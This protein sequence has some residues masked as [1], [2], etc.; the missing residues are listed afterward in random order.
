MRGP[1]VVFVL[2]AAC[3]AGDGGTDAASAGFFSDVRIDANT[4]DR[5]VVRFGTA[6]PTSCE[7]LYGL[8]ADALDTT[9]TDP[10]MAPGQRVTDHN[11]PLE[12]LV[13]LTTYFFR[14]RAT[15]ASGH[16]YTS[17]VGTLT[18]AAG[19]A[20]LSMTDVAHAAMGTT[21]TQVSSNWSGEPDDGAWGVDH[22]IDGDMYT[23][24]SSNGDGNGAYVVLDF[25]QM[26]TVTYFGFRSR[27]MRD[28]T[29][30]I[31]SVR[32]VFDGT[33]T[34]GPFDTPDPDTRYAFPLTSPIT[35]RTVR[36]E[37]IATTG[38]NTGA[39]EIQFFQP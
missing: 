23:E 12:N 36:V 31:Q 14:A 22:V 28:G 29:S 8:T 32:V 26:R 39:K 5:A 38:G 21:V 34:L 19:D 13:P 17:D 35:A 4:G 7:A 6:L 18:T 20:V 10:D 1:W 15:D 16:V 33:Q 3:G 27:K 24:W 25:G 2:S 9:A 30:I 37:A 11:V